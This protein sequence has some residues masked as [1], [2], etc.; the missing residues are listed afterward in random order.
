MPARVIGRR[1]LKRVR[2]RLPTCSLGEGA[3]VRWSA[4]DER[5]RDGNGGRAQA[6][7]ALAPPCGPGSASSGSALR[8]STSCSATARPR[9][10]PRSRPSSAASSTSCAVPATQAVAPAVLELLV[11]DLAV[12]VRQALASTVGGECQAAAG[13]RAPACRRRDRGR[14][15]DPAAQP[16]A[17][18]RGS[19][20]RG[21]HQRHAIRP[22]GGRPRAAV[23]AGVRGAGR[24]RPRRGGGAAGRTI[25]APASRRA[26]CSGW[27]RT[28]A[29]TSRSTPG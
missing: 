5:G 10:A 29:A 4:R 18:R 8:T 11:R 12:E 3:P 6:R 28:F 19:G 15:A 24:H 14:G 1:F 27:S 21:P 13:H 7:G 16:G 26:R 2:P 9:P 23:R 17:E 20:P 25:R 22:G